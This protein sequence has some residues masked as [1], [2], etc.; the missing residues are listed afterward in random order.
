MSLRALLQK[1]L[2]RFD[3][4]G[5]IEA[6]WRWERQGL[7]YLVRYAWRAA[8]FRPHYRLI[9]GD[10]DAAPLTIER[11]VF[12][13]TRLRPPTDADARLP[14]RIA[15]ASADIFVTEIDLPKVARNGLSD[16]VAFRLEEA[17]PL[18]PGDVY[19][20]LAEPAETKQG[21]LLVPIALTRKTTI[22]EV[23]RRHP[24]QE[25]AEIGAEPQ[26][27][28]ALRFRFQTARRRKT[29]RYALD[30][31]ALVLGIAALG[32][33]ALHYLDRRD[34]ALHEE[35]AQILDA[36]KAHTARA[37]PF[38][39]QPADKAPEVDGE[40]ALLAFTELTARLPRPSFVESAEAKADGLTVIF[41]AR[42]GATLPAGAQA[43]SRE[44]QRR[45]FAP[46]SVT[47]PLLPT[48][49]A[50]P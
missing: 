8:R 11:S 19:V 15:L 2:P 6:F 4:A 27:D 7:S 35:R 29:P 5:A 18:P 48:E 9:D 50:T 22:D 10:A 33:G 42:I 43:L 38:L 13:L 3:L 17:S 47:V 46:Y 24:A 16:A 44:A 12:G 25:I 34:A 31:L 21:R 41:Y 1:P 14:A 30:L 28:G 49:T 39:A 37:A 36:F 20:A 23:K 40:V 32:A 45:G 26:I